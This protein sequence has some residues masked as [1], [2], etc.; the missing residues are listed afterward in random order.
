MSIRSITNEDWSQVRAIYQKG[1]ETKVATFE[2]SPP[3][4]YEE[5]SKKFD[6]DNV[7]VHESNGEVNGWIS[8]SKFSSRCCY[9][10]VGEVSI[11]IHPDAK[12]SGIGTK[13]YNHLEASAKSSGYWTIQAQL[14]TS[15]IA[16][17]A[18][19]DSLG[20]RE[21][22]VRKNIGKLDGEWVDNFLLEKSI[23]KN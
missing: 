21:V 18:L 20:F 9:E 3:E 4:N 5:W 13:L 15:N 7:F 6:Q 14:F 10:G 22:G 2:T 1:I 19:F 23:V 8:L 16:S 12:R 11:Y 17:K